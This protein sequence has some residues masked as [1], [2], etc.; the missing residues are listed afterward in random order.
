MGI[1]SFESVVIGRNWILPIF[2]MPTSETARK[3][4]VL[5]CTISDL[6]KEA[7]RAKIAGYPATSSTSQK[8]QM[9]SNWHKI[10]DNLFKAQARVNDTHMGIDR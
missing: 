10:G 9:L 4:Q 8:S 5:Q 7:Q 1:D 2:K 3:A 6:P